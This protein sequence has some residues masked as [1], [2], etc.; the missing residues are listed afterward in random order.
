VAA[1][2]N[3]SLAL[4]CSGQV[5]SWG[6]NSFGQL[7]HN[8]K[9]LSHQARLTPKRIDAFKG[10]AMVE[11][12]ASGCHSA[13]ISS[14]AD[15]GIVY[16]WGSNKKGQLGRKEGAGTDQPYP[17]PRAVDAL[18]LDHPLSAIYEDYDAVRATQLA[19]SDW[20]SCVILRCTR[21]GKSHG[22]V[23]QFGYG[24]NYPTRV[25]FKDSK[26][27]TGSVLLSETWVPTW[28]HRVTDIVQI[29]CAQNHSIALASSGVVFTWGHNESA[30]S[31]NTSNKK[32]RQRGD[33]G[34][35]GAPRT[36]DLA[37]YGP[38]ASICASQDHCAVVT[39]AGDLVTWG[40]GAQ[41]VL[42]HGLENTWQPN[43]K[44]VPGVK[45]AVAVAA[46]HQ[47]TVVLVAPS[48]PSFTAMKVAA[49]APAMSLSTLLQQR[50]AEWLDISNC[51][52]IWKYAEDY[53]ARSLQAYCVDYMAR[54]WDAFLD[55]MCKERMETLFE[56]FLPPPEEMELERKSTPAFA[57]RTM[58]PSMSPRPVS[59]A[60]ADSL[61]SFSL[62]GKTPSH[63]NDKKKLVRKKSITGEEDP[64]DVKTLKVPSSLELSA[65]VKPF[66][67]T[68]PDLRHVPSTSGHAGSDV[69]RKHGKFVRLDQF[70]AS[71][72]S[73]S[74]SSGALQGKAGD[75]GSSASTSES[76]KNAGGLLNVA[77]I[78]G[79]LTSPWK[80]PVVS[81]RIPKQHAVLH[82]E[83]SRVSGRHPTA[84]ER[85]GSVDAS[86]SPAPLARTRKESLG[87][88]PTA[89]P[90]VTVSPSPVLAS[91]GMGNKSVLGADGVERPQIASFSL[92]AF[93]KKPSRNSR[94]NRRGLDDGS[95]EV[96]PVVSWRGVAA[97]TSP[98]SPSLMPFMPAS[99][100]SND[101]PQLK[102]LKDI[103]AEEEAR[104]AAEA[105]AKTRLGT[106]SRRTA[107]T[108]NSWG[109]CESQGHV[110]LA[111][112]QKLEEE[113]AFIEEQC[114]ILEE[115]ERERATISKSAGPKGSST[116]GSQGE[117]RR[118]G[119]VGKEEERAGKVAKKTKKKD[120]RPDSAS[121]PA[122]G[123]TAAARRGKPSKGPRSNNDA[124]DGVRGASTADAAE[125]RRSRKKKP[126]ATD[127]TAAS[128]QPRADKKAKPDRKP[129]K[130]SAKPPKGGRE[131]RAGVPAG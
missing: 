35:P 94:K 107:S 2:E 111:D 125:T 9:T 77:A 81:T 52:T 131:G 50:I 46:G 13:A 85:K 53:D 33:D 70:F 54:N 74:A 117:R 55:L 48:Q 73:R 7:G 14:E 59:F 75:A 4:S 23:W 67:D 89:S 25:N 115:I 97:G 106:Y 38:I 88:H 127:E 5:F 84:S 79:G 102:S 66:T 105:A 19:L 30:L 110:S 122:D 16:T 130:K 60:G 36:V 92:D 124:G 100:T 71:S 123:S 82:N 26:R 108:V 21:N 121:G 113:Q 32:A 120:S 17:T 58:T 57:S 43:P 41:G 80:I 64:L 6:S 93:I 109:L 128:R 68:F 12:A 101:R 119:R 87:S 63:T 129:T 37:K 27:R 126:S 18:I 44:R 31:H 86:P 42:G 83:T 76:S 8:S 114:Q 3:H 24:S 28:A 45:K 56:L 112:V 22:Q 103:Q 51:A 65:T 116:N 98:T 118:A 91:S 99:T 1:G 47:H 29:S 90:R 96:K 11:I 61:D 72:E 69:K 10:L 104:I 49:A 62:G 78:P 40:G 15:G 20:H 34:I 95:E 39:Q